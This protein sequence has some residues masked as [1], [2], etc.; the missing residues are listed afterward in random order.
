[1]RRN[2]TDVER[3]LWSHLRSRQLN[4]LK[5]RRQFPI[6]RYILDFYCL[7]KKIAIELDGGQHNTDTGRVRDDERDALLA[8]MNITVLRFWNN[9][10]I[11]N[12]D[13]VVEKILM[14]A[15]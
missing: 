10:I 11:E 1:M 3:L 5:F 14:P 12:I 13:G 9:E 2:Q 7:T 4:G 6:Q 15:K 8:R